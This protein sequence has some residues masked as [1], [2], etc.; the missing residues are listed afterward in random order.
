M[1]TKKLV[2]LALIETVA[3]ALGCCLL[4]LAFWYVSGFFD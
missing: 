3:P 4:L 2:L 1:P